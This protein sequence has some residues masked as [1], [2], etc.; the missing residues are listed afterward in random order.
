MNDD[1]EMTYAIRRDR[2]VSLGLALLVAC[3]GAGLA[4][5]YS[6]D[7]V[8]HN[9][10]DVFYAAANFFREGKNPY[11]L[12]GPGRPFQWWTPM[13]YP[14][15]ALVL[16]WPFTW[17]TLHSARIAFVGVSSFAFGYGIASSKRPWLLIAVLSQSFVSCA[18][19][20]QWSILILAAYLIPGL[21]G[22]AVAKPNVGIALLFGRVQRVPST[23]IGR[24]VA[25]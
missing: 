7:S 13:Y 4:A 12:I 18:T 3:V 14:A 17:F 20:G 23:S 9:D 10:F 5:Y 8:Y 6:S 21:R 16:L 19:L 22:V 25:F 1:A 2:L 15:P 24:V 11:A